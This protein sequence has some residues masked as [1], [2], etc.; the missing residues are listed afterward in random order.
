MPITQERMIA[1]CNEGLAHRGALT[2]LRDNLLTIL[3]QHREN[4]IMAITLI[5]GEL[6]VLQL[7]KAD[8][9]IAEAT[10][11][12]YRSR[13]NL[14]NRERMR[15]KRGTGASPPN[16]PTS[17]FRPLTDSDLQGLEPDLLA[18]YEKWNRGEEE[19]PLAPPFVAPVKREA[20]SPALEPTEQ[21]PS[22][23]VT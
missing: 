21:E 12:R 19:A 6:A 2:A 14:K 17:M 9:I 22:D 16:A 20:S 1:I 3:R 15:R 13:D 8:N 23:P 18:E 4:P 10:H 7:P 11:W 5:E